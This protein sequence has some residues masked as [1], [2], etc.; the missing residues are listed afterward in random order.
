M[1]HQEDKLAFIIK[2]CVLSRPCPFSWKGVK[3][4]PCLSRMG[5][6]ALGFQQHL[7]PKVFKNQINYKEQASPKE[8]SCLARD[9]NA[10]GLLVVL[11]G[12]LNWVSFGVCK[13]QRRVEPRTPFGS[14]V[15]YTR[16]RTLSQGIQKNT[17]IYNVAQIAS[18]S[19]C[20]YRSSLPFY[21]SLCRL[22]VAV[23]MQPMHETT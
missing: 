18:K 5:L 1:R 12:F 23:W 6:F 13:A 17:F 16:S 9:W 15:A 3:S 21:C 7:T 20:Q 14:G 19:V 4:L 2:L 22:P 8:P 11:L 10:L